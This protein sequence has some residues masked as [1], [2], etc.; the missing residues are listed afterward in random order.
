MESAVS[1][2]EIFVYPESRETIFEITAIFEEIGVDQWLTERPFI[3]LQFVNR[4]F[5]NDRE[6]S[7]WYSYQHQT[8]EIALD[9]SFDCYGQPLEWGK[10]QVVS[11]VSDTLLQA[12]QKTLTHELGH[13]IH[14]ALRE[15]DLSMFRQTMTTVRTDAISQYAKTISKPEEYFAETF[16]AWIFHRTELMEYDKLGYAMMERALK[17]LKL[18][19]GEK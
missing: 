16:V 15:L 18:E 6:V 11:Y 3:Q 17:M 8:A 14:M 5:L 2:A 1:F 9:R 10:I 13:H 12:T 7:G 19:V 4:C